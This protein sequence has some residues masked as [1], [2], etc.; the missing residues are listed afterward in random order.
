MSTAALPRR[1][2]FAGRVASAA[3]VAVLGLRVGFM[4][5]V[6]PVGSSGKG[7]GGPGRVMGSRNRVRERT[8]RPGPNGIGL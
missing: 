4:F 2:G 5:S 6:F 1:A 3:P 7:F 8:G